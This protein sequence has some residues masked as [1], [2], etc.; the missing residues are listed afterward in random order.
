MSLNPAGF[1]AEG[2]YTPDLL[3]AGD[4]PIRTRG[5]TLQTGLTLVRG[6][7]VVLT[8]T[9]SEYEAYAGGAITAGSLLGLL[10]E[11]ADTTGGAASVMIYVSGDFNANA[12]TIA[13]G[14]TLATVRDQLALQSLYVVDAVAA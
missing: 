2:T 11:D 3:I 10:V 6:Q 7:L 12:I 13:S 5:V 1:T 4:H 14:G 8:A 9:E